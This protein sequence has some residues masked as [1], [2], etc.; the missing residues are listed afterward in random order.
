M[1]S[2]LFIVFSSRMAVGLTARRIHM[3]ATQTQL[4]APQQIRQRAHH[5]G[6]GLVSNIS[7]PTA[8]PA[9]R[10]RTPSTFAAG[11]PFGRPAEPMHAQRASASQRAVRTGEGSTTRINPGPIQLHGAGQRRTTMPDPMARAGEHVTTPGEKQ[12][13][14]QKPQGDLIRRPRP[15][16]L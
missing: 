14:K 13:R 7:H 3:A 4:G 2:K 8:L 10:S 15:A 12:K 16:P 1:M 9:R 5:H 11:Q 6:T